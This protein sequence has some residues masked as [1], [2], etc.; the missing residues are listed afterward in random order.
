ML[1]SLAGAP[2]HDAAQDE[3]QKDKSTLDVQFWRRHVALDI[4]VYHRRLPCVKTLWARFH[5]PGV[6]RPWLSFVQMGLRGSVI[7]LPRFLV[8][9]PIDSMYE[10]PNHVDPDT[11]RTEP[12]AE[13]DYDQGDACC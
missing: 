8:T 7:R 3:L 13:H 11:H 4:A 12:S 1:P 5:F 6:V 10:C 2:N 9:G